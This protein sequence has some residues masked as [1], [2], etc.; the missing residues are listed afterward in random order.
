MV[1]KYASVDDGLGGGNEGSGIVYLCIYLIVCVCEGGACVER[2]IKKRSKTG[3]CVRERE[4]ESSYVCDVP[5]PWRERE[6]DHQQNL[7]ISFH[8][9]SHHISFIRFA[10]MT[11]KTHHMCAMCKNWAG[12]TTS[13]RAGHFINKINATEQQPNNFSFSIPF[14]Q[15][16]FHL[17]CSLFDH[18]PN[19]AHSYR[20]ATHIIKH[21]LRVCLS[22]SVS[23]SKSSGVAAKATQ[24]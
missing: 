16:E 23:V 15:S 18:R 9:F 17:L 19:N 24:R 1:I 8:F 3:E 5:V 4:Q 21:T 10:G 7:S 6:S 13:G 12:E 22:D 2:A 11:K 20:F 14:F